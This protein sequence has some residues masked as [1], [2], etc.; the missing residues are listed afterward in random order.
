MILQTGGLSVAATSTR[1]RLASRAIS[2]AWAV[3]MTPTCS[4]LGPIRRIGLMRIW[5]LIR[6]WS[7]LRSFGDWRSKLPG[8]KDLYLLLREKR[9]VPLPRSRAGGLEGSQD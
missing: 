8:G 5:S 6:W 9:N 2:M 4:P 3:G 7:L 1:S